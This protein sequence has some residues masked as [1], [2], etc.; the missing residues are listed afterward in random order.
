MP[1]AAAGAG[2]KFPNYLRHLQPQG[3]KFPNCLRL[4]QVPGLKSPNCLRRPHVPG[5]MRAGEHEP[6]VN[7]NFENTF[8]INLKNNLQ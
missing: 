1:P 4:L 5:G 7:A 2:T 8:I 3:L 6:E